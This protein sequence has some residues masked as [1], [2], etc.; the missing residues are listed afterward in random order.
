[1]SHFMIGYDA[2][3]LFAHDAVFLFLTYQHLFHSREQILL[4]YKFSAFLDSIDSC[5]VD[6]IGQ[7]GTDR[8]AGSQCNRIQI[9]GLVHLHILGM[10]FQDFH[11][12]FEI[13]LVYDDTAVKTSGT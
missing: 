4:A 10:Y 1:M 5:L 9:Y 13:R 2:T 12:A 7:I 3:F 6:H 11:T 8:S